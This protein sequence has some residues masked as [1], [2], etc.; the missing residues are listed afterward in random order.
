MLIS[1]VNKKIMNTKPL[2]PHPLLA[3]A[4]YVT[5]VQENHLGDLNLQVKVTVNS[6]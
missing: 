3:Y 6:M 4:I 2:S 1:K 5:Q